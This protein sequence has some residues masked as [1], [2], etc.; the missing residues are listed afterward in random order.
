MASVDSK[1]LADF[2]ESTVRHLSLLKTVE[3]GVYQASGH[4][5]SSDRNVGARASSLRIVL[6]AD[7]TATFD[8]QH[9]VDDSI[10]DIAKEESL[11]RSGAGFTCRMDLNGLLQ[12]LPDKLFD[13]TYALEV[14]VEYSFGSDSPT[15]RSWEEFTSRAHAGYVQLNRAQYLTESILVQAKWDG[16]ARFNLTRK[17]VVARHW[18]AESGRLKLFIN[19]CYFDPTTLAIKI[20]DDV[21][22]VATLARASNGSFE[23]EI[24]FDRLKVSKTVPVYFV[25]KEQGGR[26]R[27]LHYGPDESSPFFPLPGASGWFLTRTQRSVLRVDYLGSGLLVDRIDRTADEMF[28]VSGWWYGKASGQKLLLSGPFGRV[29]CQVSA[30]SSEGHFRGFA[31]IPSVKSGSVSGPCLRSGKY[32]LLIVDDLG[33]EIAVGRASSSIYRRVGQDYPGRLS[34]A[35]LSV[36]FKEEVVLEVSPSSRPGERSPFRRKVARL[37]SAHTSVEPGV[38]LFE[39]FHGRSVG[40]NSLPVFRKLVDLDRDLKA[41]W[42][43]ADYSVEVPDDTHPVLI[44]SSEYF[45]VLG[46]CELHVT[47]NWLPA[48]IVRKQGRSILQTWHG[49][50]LKLLGL[51]RFGSGSSAQRKRMRSSTSIW[52]GLLS[53]NAY[54]TEIFRRCYAY[55][56]PIHEVGYPRNDILV[57][58]LPGDRLVELKERLG[59]PVSSKVLL[60]M[61][62]WR[63]NSKTIYSDLDLSRLQNGLGPEWTILVR[64]HSM[65]TKHG[66]SSLPAGVVDVSVFPSAEILY[67]LADVFVTDYSSAMFDFTVTGKPIMFFV[68]DI[69]EYTSMLRGVYFNL[70]ECAPG[71]LIHSVDDLIVCVLDASDVRSSFSERYREWTARFNRWDDGH[72]AE[73]VA[74]ILNSGLSN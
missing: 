21:T 11:D 18:L 30:Y 68:P 31:A 15:Q 64:G 13:H 3:P 34:S 72:A 54:S 1:F 22:D 27:L 44:H 14:E 38:L 45:D 51:D 20:G 32:R 23:A 66:Q 35:R 12:D 40:D 58:G 39:S 59:I 70:E 61:P 2:S 17:A 5:Y 50:P 24:E 6:D 56:G 49:T 65:N 26:S 43:V 8:V 42:T 63:E 16:A 53:Q 36:N 73:R 4:I 19:A 10:N 48:G 46:R 71:P 55:D 33:S 57:E 28:E 41:Y 60:Y 29:E 25:L 69:L 67:L 7:R 47:N 62:T 9:V 37:R 52:D 74:E